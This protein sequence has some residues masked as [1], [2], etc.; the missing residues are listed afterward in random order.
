[1]FKKNLTI[2]L[3]LLIISILISCK[4]KNETIKEIKIGNQI[5]QTE[6]LEVKKFSNGDTI[7]FVNTKEDWDKFEKEKKPAYCYFNHEHIKGS[8]FRMLYNWYA[9]NDKRGL[10]PKGWHIPSDGEWTELINFLGGTAMAAQ[11]M[12]AKNV[13]EVSNKDSLNL[14]GTDESGFKAIPSGRQHKFEEYL[15]DV[16]N[17]SNWWS[18]TKC[19]YGSNAAYIVRIVND[20]NIVYQDLELS[21]Y[22]C[23][24]R[25]I[26]DQKGLITKENK[27]RKFLGT[28]VSKGQYSNQMDRKVLR[29]E[30]FGENFIIGIGNYNGN[31]EKLSASY[32][33]AFDK[34]V[35]TD[36]SKAADIIYNPETFTILKSGEEYG[37]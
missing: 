27:T 23:S 14:Y 26:K 10:A 5:W 8:K 34:L 7:P 13:W 4:S 6:N 36:I 15:F 33:E 35:I 2:L 1:M 19:E 20:N 29:I 24:V 25:C 17:M 32:N 11:K 30:N 12:K 31:I 22:Y 3:N 18:S 28:W 21:N 9:V 37:R 16:N